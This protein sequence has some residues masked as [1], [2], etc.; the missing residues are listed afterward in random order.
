MNRNIPYADT[1][2]VSCQYCMTRVA[3]DKSRLRITANINYRKSC[4]GVIKSESVVDCVRESSRSL[5]VPQE[6][7]LGSDQE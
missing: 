2:F 6:E 5:H 1:F 4:W 7:L 3:H